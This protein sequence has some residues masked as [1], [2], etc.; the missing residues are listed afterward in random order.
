MTHPAVVGWGCQHHRPWCCGCDRASTVHMRQEDPTVRARWKGALDSSRSNCERS[1]AGVIKLTEVT[2]CASVMQL[3][4]VIQTMT[5]LSWSPSRPLPSTSRR[6]F[7]TVQSLLRR[8]GT[9]RVKW[10]ASM[11]HRKAPKSW[12]TTSLMPGVIILNQ[13]DTGLH[14]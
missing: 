13:E 1:P 7:P 8:Q 4:Y 9:H 3:Q 14:S 2:V 10:E 12:G 5:T 6:V 11:R